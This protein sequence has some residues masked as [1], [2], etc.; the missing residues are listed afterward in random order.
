MPAQTPPFWSL[1]KI[2]WILW[3][4]PLVAWFAMDGA[5]VFFLDTDRKHPERVWFKLAAVLF[6]VNLITMLAFREDRGRAER[7]DLRLPEKTLVYL[8][9]LGGLPGALLAMRI[10]R[11]KTSKWIFQLRLCFWAA[12]EA[13]FTAFAL[14]STGSIANDIRWGICLFSLLWWNLAVLRGI[15]AA[16]PAPRDRARYLG[17][18]SAALLVFLSASL[19]SVY[20]FENWKDWPHDAGRHLRWGILASGAVLVVFNEIWLSRQ[21]LRGRLP[22]WDPVAP[23]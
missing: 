4:L 20:L 1:N 10:W 22:G 13:A 9:V 21:G 8:V 16:R 15:L 2:Y 19:G 18:L 17:F 3:I 12:A 5:E 23:A 11:H 14:P 6:F 7:G